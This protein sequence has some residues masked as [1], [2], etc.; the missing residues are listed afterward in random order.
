M[1]NMQKVRT[2]HINLMEKTLQ[3]LD[4]M[5][6]DVSQEIATTLC[7]LSDAPNGWTTVEVV[8]HLRDFDK[9]FHSR[10]QMM[11]D[12]EEPKLPAYDHE[13]MAVEGNYSEQ[14]LSAALDALRASR[15]EFVAFYRGLSDA[16]WERSGVHPE[17]GQFSLTDSVMQVG[18]HDVMHIEQIVR[19]LGQK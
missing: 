9:V 10:A 6:S 15:A 7:D 8:C 19:I 12:Q 1:S 18:H 11:V 13:E 14:S 5:M 4:N 3:I 17:S 2:R 16:E